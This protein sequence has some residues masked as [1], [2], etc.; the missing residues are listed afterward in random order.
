MSDRSVS[1]VE[2]SAIVALIAIDAIFA[3]TTGIGIRRLGAYTE[4]LAII[5]ALWPAL[6][7]LTRAT[8]FAKGGAFLAEAVAKALI[9]IYVA[10][11]LEYYLA[12]S[13]AP[14]QDD[15]LI[16]ADHALGFD[17]PA[18]FA[19]FAVHPAVRQVIAFAYFNLANEAMLVLL[20]TALF[21]PARA[22]QVPTALILSSLMTVPVLW[23]F[24]V[25]GAFVAFDHASLP[26]AS[27][28]ADY[29]GMR[30][31]AL[32]Q[33]PLDDPRGIVSFPSFHASSAVLLTYLV[34]G[35][36]VL[37]PATL[38]FNGL[39]VLGTPVF[40]GHYLVDVLAG[41]AVAGVT[42]AILEGVDLGKELRRLALFPRFGSPSRGDAAAVPDKAR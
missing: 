39:M 16:R 10:T 25:A 32:A 22:R 20:V 3:A 1:V 13:P 5:F 37:F 36:P 27:Y 11:V 23:I 18:V 7:L 40:G 17:W 4:T 8:G 35:I 21:Y 38:L 30:A 34:R 42:I 15:L 2:W 6:A 31:H 14:L 26:H 33:I 29:L 9:F 41:L 24:P 28:T 19:W 12:T